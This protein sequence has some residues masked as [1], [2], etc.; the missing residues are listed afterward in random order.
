MHQFSIITPTYNRSYFLQN[1]Y[2]SLCLQEGIDF[3]WIIVDDGSTDNTKEIVDCFNEKIL[4]KYVYQNNAGKPTAMNTGIRMADSY[5]S[6]SFDSD[7]IFYPDALKTVW[8]YFDFNTK[9]FENDCVCLSGLCQYENGDIIGNKFPNDYYV[10][11]HIRYRLNKNIR[12]DKQ[13]FILTKILKEYSFPLFQNEKNIAP[14]IIMTRIS[15]LYSTLYVNKILATKQF[16]QGGL[17]TQN[18]WFMYPKGSE[19]FYNESSV[20]PFKLGLQ[21]YNSGQYIFF[22]KMIKREN[23]YSNALNKRIFPLGLIAYFLYSIKVLFKRIRL[24]QILNNIIK[25]IIFKIFRIK[26][27]YKVFN[28]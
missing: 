12:G 13:E 26:N 18:Y 25:S 1:V 7:D 17:S 5:I 27:N 22:S 14:G 4:L 16:L 6:V 20:P 3:E 24:F 21:I 9:K 11:D 19:I 8:S 10:S 23:I 2:H 28:T 15:F